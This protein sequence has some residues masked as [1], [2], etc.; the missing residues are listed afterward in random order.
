[1]NGSGVKLAIVAAMPREIAGLAKHWERI[2]LE[3]QG[4]KF[5]AWKSVRAVA[6]CCGTGAES[7]ALV[8]K[9]AIETF[10]PEMVTS[11]GFAGSLVP[12][13]AAGSVIVPARVVDG[14]SGHEFRTAFGSGTL[15][16]AADV[17]SGPARQALASRYGAVAAD[18]EATGV[19][20]AAES[21]GLPFVAVK[22]VSDEF[23][24]DVAFTSAFVRPERFQTGAFLAHVALRPWLWPAVA[25]L[26]RNT[27]SAAEA[28]S[29]ALQ[30]WMEDSEGF[31]AR[32]E[33]S[34][35]LPDRSQ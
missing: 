8:T 20:R 30:F 9:V 15:V 7:A 5:Q 19:A 29:S 17:V 23:G 27:A 10:R 35:A 24:T 12:N 34:A 18:M 21:A 33:S 3:A 4:R 22:S 14:R 13:L 6:A 11:V 16:T 25:K 2:S 32:S 1:M 28:L 31:A 26:A